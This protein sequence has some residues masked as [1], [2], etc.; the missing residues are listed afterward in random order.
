MKKLY[1][2]AL[3]E[4]FEVTEDE[5]RQADLQFR[6]ASEL[7]ASFSYVI[8]VKI[9]GEHFNWIY[10]SDEDYSDMIAKRTKQLDAL[11]N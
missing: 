3:H 9:F 5:F 2:A 11:L 10:K 1:D 7:L 4:I 8:P 6:K